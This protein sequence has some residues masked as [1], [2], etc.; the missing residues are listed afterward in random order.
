[1]G[2]FKTCDAY[3]AT[4]G[5]ACAGAWEEHDDTC[6]VLQT[7]TCD[8]DFSSMPTSDAICECKNPGKF[9]LNLISHFNWE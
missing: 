1:M 4:Q 8:F 9:F 2:T 5:F 6:Q 7:K 3:C